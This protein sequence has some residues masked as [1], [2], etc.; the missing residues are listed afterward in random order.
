VG[1]RL[2][3]GRLRHRVLSLAGFGG[4][5]PAHDQSPADASAVLPQAVPSLSRP[6]ARIHRILSAAAR[7]DDRGA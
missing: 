4:D 6:A 7:K 1:A 5:L 2:L 3:A